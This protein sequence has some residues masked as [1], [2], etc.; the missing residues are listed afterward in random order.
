[1]LCCQNASQSQLSTLICN[2]ATTIQLHLMALFRNVQVQIDAV[3]GG[4]KLLNDPISHNCLGSGTK[5]RRKAI[6]Q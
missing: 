4:N 3:N 1:M 2:D 5:L 6:T